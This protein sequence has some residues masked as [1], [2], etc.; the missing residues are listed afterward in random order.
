M[1]DALGLAE[2]DEPETKRVAA[3]T[4]SPRR[5]SAGSG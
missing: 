4:P 1:S 2:V 5:A 3:G